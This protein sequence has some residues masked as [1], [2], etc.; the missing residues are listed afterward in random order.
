MRLLGPVLLLVLLLAGSCTP[1]P[2]GGGGGPKATPSPS[3]STGG[4]QPAANAVT[5]TVRNFA[6]Q[7]AS[8]EIPKG[9]TV[10]W[11]FEDAV[12]HNAKSDEGSAFAWDSGMHR[13]GETFTQRFDTA[14]TFDYHCTPHPNMRGKVVVR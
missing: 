10:T 12:A 7:P 4:E 14:G 2:A 13:N 9:G 11:R 8:V 3:A 1:A 5:V 6:F